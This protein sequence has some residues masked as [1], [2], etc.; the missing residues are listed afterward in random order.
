MFILIIS[1]C[2]IEW[3]TISYFV[4]LFYMNVLKKREL[5]FDHQTKLPFS[6][7]LSLLLSD[8]SFEFE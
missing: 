5:R 3:F 4:L 1:Q 8:E 2:S 7:L 6:I